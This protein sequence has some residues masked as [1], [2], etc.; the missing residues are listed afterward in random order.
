MNN[1]QA[2]AVPADP[3]Q[4]MVEF[5]HVHRFLDPAERG[6]QTWRVRL[7]A[8]DRPVGTFRVTRGLYWKS[9]NLRERLSD[10]QGF[11]EVVAGQLLN[12]D[13][14]FSTAFEAFVEMAGSIVVVELLELAEPWDDAA[15]VAGVVA[16]II[17]RLADND[18]AVVFPRADEPDAT[19]CQEV[20]AQAAALLSA[21][22]FSDELQI[23]DTALD[24]PEQAAKQVRGHLCARI[25]VVGADFWDEDDEGTGDEDYPVLTA[26]SAAVL[27]RALEDLSDEA[28]REV[29]SLGGEPLGPGV[30]GLFGSLPRVTFNQGGPWR[31]QMARAF[32][33]LAAD[34]A[35]GVEVVPRCT[36]EE[37][38]LHLGIAR[39]RAL[40]R[41][42]PRLVAESVAG[43]PEDRRDFGW[44]AASEELFEDG[45]VLMLFDQ[46][47][48][49]IENSGNEANQALGMVNLAPVDWFT[50]FDADFARDPG[51][52]FRNP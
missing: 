24:A 11:P 17:D 15:L 49:G 41:N 40:T 3:T 30:G 27:R 45:D 36:G 38:A 9:G 13:G 32:D 5:T 28:W 42:R 46:S 26:R 47:L 25:A 20:L 43:L 51:R 39:A 19:R 34:L 48:D 12:S 4:L 8:Q 44:E 29:A 22:Y 10:E 50:A 21:A 37:M 6:V 7:T 33:D 35:G 23:I 52:G 16:S 14:S 18:C 1:Q 31:R 2:A